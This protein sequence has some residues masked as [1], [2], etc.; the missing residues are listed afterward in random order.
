MSDDAGRSSSSLS[1]KTAVRKKKVIRRMKMM[2]WMLLLLAAVEGQ[3]IRIPAYIGRPVNRPAIRIVPSDSVV[4]RIRKPDQPVVTSL[5]IPRDSSV[6]RIQPVLVAPRVTPRVNVQDALNQMRLRK[7][8]SLIETTNLQP[9]FQQAGPVTLFAPTDEA[10]SLLSVP[11]DQRRLV[12]FV[13]QHVVKGR[14]MP[15][16]VRN[17][18]ILPSLRSSGIPLRLNVYEDGQMLSVSGSQFLD[19]ARDAGNVRIQPIDR[20]LYPISG[21][22]LA[23]EAR[24]TFP[25]LG[26]MLMKASLTQQ[27]TSGTF[28][29]FA[30]TNEAFSSLPPEIQEKLMENSTL[31]HKVLLN[32]VVPGTHYSAVLA[33]GYS[34]KTMGGEPI[35]FTNRRGLILANGVPVVKADISVS[36]GVIHAINRLL[37]P[38]E[39]FERR[40]PATIAPPPFTEAPVPVPDP[41]TEYLPVPVYMEPSPAVPR[42]LSKTIS[43]PLNLPDGRRMTFNSAN[44]LLRRSL[45]LSTLRNNGSEMGYTM[46]VPTDAAFSAIGQSGLDSL[47]RNSKL[48]RRMLLCQLMEGRINLTGNEDRPIRSLGGTIVLSSMNGGNNL[49]IGGA[50]VLSVRQASD[51][52]VLVTDRVTFPPA[53]RNVADALMPFPKLKDIV[54]TRPNIEQSLINDGSVYTIFAPTDAALSTLQPFQLQDKMF[55]SEL[56]WSHVVRGAYYRSRLAPGLKLTTVRGNTI[57]IHRSP[58]GALFVNEKPITADEIIAGNG[59]IHPIDTLLFFPQSPEP[60]E[61]PITSDNDLAK[62]AKEFDATQFLDWMKMA[63][64][65]DL[66]KSKTVLSNGCTLFLPTNAALRNMPTTLRF[67][68]LSDRARLKKFILYHVSSR[69]FSWNTVHDNSFIP[70][71]IPGRDIRCNVYAKGRM[72]GVLTVNGCRVTAMRPLSPE[73][74]VTVAVIDEAMSSPTGDLPITVAQTPMLTNFSKILTVAGFRDI[75]SDGGPYTLFAPNACAFSEMDADEYQRLIINSKVALEFVKRYLVKGCFYRN[76]LQDSQTLRTEANT[77]LAVKITP[78][79]ILVSGAKVLYGDMST[80]NGVLHVIASLLLS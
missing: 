25:S 11:G 48:L 61:P 43:E 73:S 5:A 40:R 64:L 68:T 1:L 39:L 8:A 34:L 20:V 44:S 31:L 63:Q 45:L 36:N 22:D 30:P 10:F 77:Y 66:L 71:L 37:L 46:L 35:H 2:L 42:P 28:T 24:L 18:F 80:T 50:R 49:M 75:I 19:D 53:S 6:T 41:T 52:M 13:L 27:L 9:V 7:M 12:D 70:S 51:G 23:T 14:V 55:M 15:Q 57:I 3:Q 62:I 56:F 26:E 38:Q 58:T 54:R 33:H 60:T 79:C 21:E 72:P 17:D 69:A 67:V 47:R 16:D 32:H 65:Q 74:N 76:G 78:D 29:L 4:V 59:V